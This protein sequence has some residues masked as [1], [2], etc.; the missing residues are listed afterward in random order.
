MEQVADVAAGLFKFVQHL[1]RDVACISGCLVI[2][3]I[4]VRVFPCTGS[5]AETHNLSSD[6]SI[7]GTAVG[8][9]CKCGGG[10]DDG[11]RSCLHYPAETM[12]PECFY[13]GV[14]YGVT[15]SGEC[16]TRHRSHEM[17][18]LV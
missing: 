4:S 15:V 10:R 17:R 5:M 18:R 2:L 9:S 11:G 3:H 12:A 1:H 6:N 16:L 13:V 7:S 14:F 8:T